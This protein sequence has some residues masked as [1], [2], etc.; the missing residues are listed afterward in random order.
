MPVAIT[1]SYSQFH[2]HLP[3]DRPLKNSIVLIIPRMCVHFGEVGLV[4]GGIKIP[5]CSGIE[6]YTS[7]HKNIKIHP[8]GEYVNT[9]CFLRS[10]NR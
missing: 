4:N 9:A 10:L 8:S 6:L 5:K 7:L 1:E 2:E 3:G